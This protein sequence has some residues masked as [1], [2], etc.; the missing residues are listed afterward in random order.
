MIQVAGRQGDEV[1]DVGADRQPALQDL[2]GRR[3]VH[4]VD[5]VGGKAGE[6][7]RPRVGCGGHAGGPAYAR[8]RCT[9]VT[10]RTAPES[11][12]RCSG[13]SVAGSTW[14]V[15]ASPRSI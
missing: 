1:G 5:D 2:G 7:V 3:L 6:Q 9:P 13:P 12:L 14:S 8:A 11:R 10:S 4:G 15:G